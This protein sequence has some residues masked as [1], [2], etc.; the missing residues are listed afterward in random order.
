MLVA[1]VWMGNFQYLRE[2]RLNNNQLYTVPPSIGRLTLLRKIFLQN[3][4]IHRLPFEML[5]LKLLEE[6][7][8]D[9]RS[10]IHKSTKAILSNLESSGCKIIH[11]YNR[12]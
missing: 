12:R 10:T 8:I 1:P 5:E 3:N 6:L 2:L 4:N 7:H 11:D 9:F